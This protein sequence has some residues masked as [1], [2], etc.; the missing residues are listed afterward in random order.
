MGFEITENRGRETKSNKDTVKR[1]KSII[2]N[3]NRIPPGIKWLEHLPPE[4]ASYT[5]FG[6]VYELE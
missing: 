5:N 3:V 4:F 2:K 6:P 1:G